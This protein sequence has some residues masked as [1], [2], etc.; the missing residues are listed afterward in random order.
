MSVEIYPVILAHTLEEYVDKLML[1]EASSSTW[2]QVDLMDG[3]FVPN[4]TVMPSE[5]MSIATRLKLEAHMMT[6]NPE[7]FFSDLTVAGFERVLLHRECRGSFEDFA[8]LVKSAGD[9]FSQVGVVLNPETEP[10]DFSSLPIVAIQ[11]MGVNPGASG[12]Q[13]LEGTYDRVRVLAERFPNIK[14]AVDG[15]VDEVTIKELRKAGAERFVIA[16]HLFVNSNVA[17]NLA[18]FNQLVTGGT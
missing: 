8:K 13:L 18:Y 14:I 1:V 17:T 4:I 2:V 16:S 15:G 12:Q 7:Q 3:H 5:I 6:V 11:Q 9:Y 10:E